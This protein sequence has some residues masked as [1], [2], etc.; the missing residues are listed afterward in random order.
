MESC[1]FINDDSDSVMHAHHAAG[2]AHSLSDASASPTSIVK[3]MHSTRG[4]DEVQ[5]V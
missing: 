2:R 4:D 5:M 1:K 3:Y